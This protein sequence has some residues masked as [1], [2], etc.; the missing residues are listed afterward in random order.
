MQNDLEEFFSLVNFA[1][2]DLFGCFAE[3]KNFCEIEVN[4]SFFVYLLQVY[5]TV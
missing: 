5:C 2:P 3:F 1:R 4:V